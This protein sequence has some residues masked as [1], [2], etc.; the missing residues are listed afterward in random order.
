MMKTSLY[1]LGR[2]F[3][4]ACLAAGLLAGCGAP[5]AWAGL[6]AD[7][8]AMQAELQELFAAQ[9]ALAPG[10]PGNRALE[11][12]VERRFAAS[13]F[14]HG[15]MVF[16]APVFTPGKTRLR[17][18]DGAELVILPMHP[19]LLRPGNFAEARFEAPLVYLGRGTME[20]LQR[21]G[22]LNLAGAIA[23]MD[24]AGGD[25][26]LDL[27]RF[28]IRGFVFLAADE[29]TYRDACG[30][31]YNTEVAVP[32]FFAPEPAASALRAAC[33]PG[34]AIPAAMLA[35]PSRMRR[36]SLR[37]FW[38][39]I[40]GRDPDRSREVVVVTAPMDADSVVP[41]LAAGGDAAGNLYLLL[42]LLDAWR[43]K[44]PGV[45]V[46]LVAVN[47]HTQNFLG[48]RQLAW[49]LLGAA[50]SVGE[51]RNV[52]A[53]QLRVENLFV[54]Q[55]RRLQ[56]RPVALAEAELDAA[57]EI[58]WTLAELAPADSAAAA[59]PPNLDAIPGDRLRAAIEQAQQRLRKQHGG[60]LA[61]L[62]KNSR[63]RAEIDP[64]LRGLESIQAWEEPRLRAL[65]NEAWPVFADERII[66]DW[67]AAMDASTGVRLALKSRLQN[68][69]N[70]E[71]NM[72]KMALMDLARATGTDDHAAQLADLRQQRQKLTKLL[73]LF[74]KIDIGFGVHRTR[75]RQIAVNGPQRELLA[76][77]NQNLIAE[78]SANAA[79]YRESL[80]NDVANGTIRDALGAQRVRL[81][82]SLG[83]DWGADGMGFCA[84]NPAL[85]DLWWRRLGE[86]TAR[87]GRETSAARPE[88]SPFVDALSGEGG[89]PQ[90][91]YFLSWPSPAL[92]FQA[93][94]G[95]AAI[96]LR[97]AFAGPRRSFS[98][99]NRLADLD[100]ARFHGLQRWWIAYFSNL[101]D[102]PR[103]NT[104][105]VSP[106]LPIPG[107]SLLWSSLAQ[108]FEMDEFASKPTPSLAVPDVAIAAYSLKAQGGALPCLVDGDVVNVFAAM[109]D[110]TGLATLYGLWESPLAT[111][112]YQVDTNAIALRSSIDKGQIQQ[113]MQMDSNFYRSFSKTLP[114]FPCREFV[115]YDRADP[116]LVGSQPIGVD[117][118]WVKSGKTL[119]DPQKY[120][121]HGAGCLSRALSHRSW[122]PAG[123]YLQR[124][125]AGRVQD[126]LILLTGQR[127]FA[128]NS[129]PKDPEGAGYATPEAWG[130]DFFALAAGDMHRVNRHR[131][132]QMRGVVNELVDEFL[133]A[134]RAALEAM[135]A[136]AARAD[137]VAYRQAVARAIGHQVK[138]YAQIR[139]MNADMLKAIIVY[140]ALMLPFC[141]FLQKLIF[142]FKKLEHELAAFVALFLATY[143][144]FR[145]IHPAFAIAMS[146][147][148][149]FIAFVLGTVGCFVTWMLKSRFAAEMDL[150]FRGTKGVDTEVG[151]GF[152]GQTAMLI[153]VNN[154]KRRRTRTVLTTATVVLVIFTM[155]A[156]S[157]VSRKV[158]P[159]LIPRLAE[160]PYTGL[161]FMWPGGAPMDEQTPRAIENLYGDRA[162]LLVRRV[163]IPAAVTAE[164]GMRWR[165]E[166]RDADPRWASVTAALSLSP[167]EPDFSGPLP[168]LYG[169]PF[170][171]DDAREVII[172]ATLAEALGVAPD[173]LSRLS[174]RF[175][176]R[177]LTVVGILDDA[178]FRLLRDLDPDAPLLPRQVGNQGDLDPGDL[179]LTHQAG[180]AIGGI[181][182]DLSTI[183]F[184]PPG[185]AEELG[186]RPFSVSVRLPDVPAA[187]G[188]GTIWAEADLCLRATNARFSLG[189]TRPFKV[190]ENAKHATAGGVY[191]VSGT[192][193]TS[194]GGLSR[195]VIPLLIAGL[196]LFNTMLGT[197][198]ERKAEIAIYNAIGLNPHHIFIFFLAE[199]LVYG[200]IGA[201]GGYL[202]GQ[203]LAII[204][205]TFHLVQGLNVNFSS[206]I[207]V[208]A[209][210]F[211]MALVLA[212]TLYPAWVATRTAVPSGTRR[213]AAPKH[214]G[215]TMDLALPFIYQPE[216]APGVMAYLHEYFTLQTDASL[217]DLMASARVLH[218]GPDA[219][220]HAAYRAEYGMALAPFD[221]GVTQ[222]VHLQARFDP[223]LESYGLRLRIRRESGQ[224]VSWAAI[225]RPFLERLRKLLLQW[226]NL[227][228]S[229]HQWYVAL[230]DKIFAAPNPD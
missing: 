110:K 172:P 209:I 36:E 138:A 73:V 1:R 174:L 98:P 168:L 198:Y 109:G 18:A 195:L 81:V 2:V 10:L 170:A 134:G 205:Q 184:L 226:R 180:D 210:L 70:R 85:R 56:F 79:Q 118:L 68:R 13:G 145:L 214:D 144:G 40:P 103:L 225:N 141:Y 206:L 223:D 96:T 32:R 42:N 230:A 182:V 24:F 90:E 71:L 142:N 211:T 132:D 50:E 155:L 179:L 190:G 21:A 4:G 139:S 78:A 22:G 67:R 147:E 111:T 137:H 28:G 136:A 157:S 58:L 216:L 158:R 140:M 33:R 69:V 91:H 115:V 200:V 229:R 15:S 16:D 219:A 52:L 228:P 51:L 204:A 63:A 203:I 92:V 46:L 126:S 25:R 164:G 161:F 176:G 20:D 143:T 14:A 191:L 5:A 101:L 23:V 102:D 177:D 127:R 199:A 178:R 30:K 212:S 208:W 186:A 181:A 129:T 80:D 197:V 113:S 160:A 19:T 95:T 220:G 133:N 117:V 185:L 153:G 116:S 66:D 86:L 125:P 193:R 207:V 48:E 183:M 154:M 105:E 130:C 221:L 43:Q 87:V 38:A 97:S 55:Y 108:A 29:Y 189:S 26:W 188:S 169:R 120:G 54:E 119:S 31:I 202:I 57:L 41:E 99:A 215:E 171:A 94:Q 47:G 53:Q 149:I 163:L 35:E 37:N 192:Y 65:L 93:A 166:R 8:R 175:L 162:Q 75:Y 123:V 89:L 104:P 167:R 7:P 156:F 173:D 12:A 217:S 148:A 11:A 77:F 64:G 128:V 6:P 45:S 196:L 122:G 201:I 9:G 106:A 3:R 159:T 222:A 146:P 49:H 224:D 150:L 187:D 62:F 227:D 218:R 100:P 88:R 59:A 84:L 17:L 34:S 74:N 72:V 135:A 76:H 124:R 27:L 194:I 213:W 107:N 152:V 83:A 131:A 39:L 112:A 114:M 82:I 151:A 165:L 60:F 61:S 121:V 44:P